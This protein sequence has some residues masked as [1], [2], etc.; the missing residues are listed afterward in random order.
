MSHNHSEYL[1]HNEKV[2]VFYIG[3]DLLDD[4]MNQVKE[5]FYNEL[6]DDIPA[7]AF[8]TDVMNK[9][10]SESGIIPTAREAMKKLYAIPEIQAAQKEYLNSTNTEDKYLKRGEFGELLLYHLL[11]EYFNADALISKIYFKD[12]ASIPAHGF[13]AVHVDLEKETLWLGESKLYISSTSAIDELVKDVVGFRDKNGKEH[14]GHF[15]TD[16]FNSEFQIITNRVHD[17]GKEYP[18]FIEKLIDPNTKTLDKLANINIAL[19][20]GFNSKALKDFDETTF[21]DSLNSEIEELIVKS[22][23]GLSKHSWNQHLNL[24]LFM[25]PLDDKR[26]FVSSLH[27]KLKGAQQL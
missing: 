3:F 4:G 11:H 15:N 10:L 20:A 24:F 22:K 23:N 6:F 1:K 9:K 26:E 27:Q 2:H 18:E 19:F 16:F 12:S 8:G 7:F 13:D 21:S 17:T 14:K 25:F 5:K